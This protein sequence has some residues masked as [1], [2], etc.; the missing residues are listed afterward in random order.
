MIGRTTLTLR[1]ACLISGLTITLFGPPQTGFSQ[2]NTGTENTASENT[3]Q[4]ASEQVSET[5]APADNQDTAA[6]NF[7]SDDSQ[8]DRPPTASTVDGEEVS[9]GDERQSQ[10]IAEGELSSADSGD[11]S[12][13]VVLP[14]DRFDG[15]LLRPIGVYQSQLVGLV[16]KDFIPVALDE[17]RT[18]LTKANEQSSRNTE[19]RLLNAFYDVRLDDQMLVSDHSVLAFEHAVDEGVRH[20]LGRV[21]LAIAPRR[22]VV[23]VGANVTAGSQSRFEAD[24]DGQ[25]IAVVPKPE[26]KASDGDA[27]SGDEAAQ[28]AD[29]ERD[30]SNAEAKVDVDEPVAVRRSEIQFSWTL[31][32][33]SVGAMRKYDLRLP[34]AAQTRLVISV[35]QDVMLESRHG[36]LVERPGPPPDAD[37]QSRA[38]DIRWYVLEAGGLNRVE[39]YARKRATESNSNALIVR[40]ETK[41][42]DVDL[43]GLKWTHHLSLEMPVRR[44]QM[45]LRCPV[46][47][48][49]DVQ[50]NFL[51][52]NYQVIHRTDGQAVISVQIPGKFPADETPPAP[53]G[54]VIPTP[55]ESA[56]ELMTLTV[57]GH[58]D[59]DLG[60][61]LCYLPSV[62]PMDQ[63]VYWSPT[64][65]T[66]RITING[67][68]EVAKW[69]LPPGWQQSV[70]QVPDQQQTILTGE[71]PSTS[72]P[73]LTQENS[74]AEAWSTIGLIQRDDRVVNHIWT[75]MRV[76]EEPVHSIRATTR[77]S[78]RQSAFDLSPIMIDA[79]QDWIIDEVR[80]VQTKRRVNVAPKARVISIWPSTTESKLDEFEIEIVSRRNLLGNREILRVPPSWIIRPRD[81]FVHHLIAVQA[82]GRRRWNGDSV[83]LPD[84]VDL[85]SLDAQAVSFLQPMSE[86]IL[87]QS[88]SG[89]IPALE[90]EQVDVSIGVSLKHIIRDQ[91]GGIAETIV[92]RSATSQPIRELGVLTGVL[93]EEPFDWSLRRTDHSATVSLPPSDISEPGDDPLGTY[94][95]RL[96]GREFS[97]YELVGR[98]VLKSTNDRISIQLPSVRDDSSQ[99]AELFLSEP[100]EIDA[101][102]EGVALVPGDETLPQ[103]TPDE[104]SSHLSQRLRYDPAMRPEINLQKVPTESRTCL[105]WKQNVEVIASS[106]NEDIVQ[107][108]AEIST[109][110]L[111][112]IS[113]D[114][115][116]ELISIQ[117]NGIR[118]KISQSVDGIWFTPEN[119]TD[120]IS[121]SMRRRHQSSGWLRPC[122]APQV[123]VEGHRLEQQL[124]YTTD[125][126]TVLLY[127]NRS[128]RTNRGN[129]ASSTTKTTPQLTTDMSVTLWLM[130]RHIALAL[131]WLASLVMVQISWM[132]A[133]YVPKGINVLFI[134]LVLTASSAVIFWQW[135]LPILIWLAVPIALGGLIH[136][137]N[138]RRFVPPGN[139][140]PTLS[141]VL[142]RDKRESKDSVDFSMT[143]SWWIFFGGLAFGLAA[144]SARA[145]SNVMPPS[146]AESKRPIELLLPLDL[147]HRPTGDKVYLSRSD[148]DQLRNRVNADVAVEAKFQSASYRIILEPSRENGRDLDAEIQADYQITTPRESAKLRLPIRSDVIRRIELINGDESQIARFSVDGKTGVIVD[149]PRSN[150]FE[151]RVTFVPSLVTSRN[152]VSEDLAT[153]TPPSTSADSIDEL[154]DTAGVT[155]QLRLAIPIVHMA[156]LI[157]EAPREV[158]VESLGTP[159]GRTLS[160][161]ELGRYEADLGPVGEI[162]I[163]YQRDRRVEVGRIQSLRRTYRI[164]A[165]VQSTIVECEIDSVTPIEA[166]Q[167]LS[168]TILGPP[169]T[170]LDPTA[171]KLS[172]RAR[173]EGPLEEASSASSVGVYQFIKQTETPGPI[174]LFWQLQSLLNDPTSTEDRKL[175][176]VPDVVATNSS[177][178]MQTMF[179]IESAPAVR[180]TETTSSS[181]AVNSDDFLNRWVGYSG[182]L[183]RAF[184]VENDFPSFA[185]WQD[186]D[187][188]ASLLMQHHLHVDSS[189]LTLTL[190]AIVIDPRPVTN[191]VLIAIPKGFELLR[192]SIN[193]EAS[194]SSLRTKLPDGRTGVSLGDRRV[195][196]QMEI[197]L[198]CQSTLA[199]N[200]K[201]VIPNFEAV[202]AIGPT[203]NYRVTR[204]NTVSVELTEQAE[205]N[206]IAKPAVGRQELLA[207]QIPVM[208]IPTSVMPPKSDKDKPDQGRFGS[209]RVRRL[210]R[211]TAVDCN[212]TSLMRYVDGQWVCNT[213]L[214]LTSN[215]I[216][217]YV[218]VEIPGAW[219]K[220]V[221]V[222]NAD[223]WAMRSSNDLVVSVVRIHFDHEPSD[224]EIQPSSVLL[225][226]TL[227]N[228]DQGRVTVPEIRVLGNIVGRR[229]VLLPK[230][231]TTEKIDWRRRG[232]REAEL[233]HDW[234]ERF[235][236]IIDD[237]ALY[238]AY[239]IVTKNWSIRL[240]PLSQTAVDPVALSCDARVFLT[241]ERATVFQ[242]FDV[243]PE[244]GNEV[245]LELP[246]NAQCIGVWAAGREISQPR[247]SSHEY[248]DDR[249]SDESNNRRRRLS[250]P[251]AY[252]RLPQSIEIF[253]EIESPDKVLDDYLCKPVNIPSGIQWLSL[254]RAPSIE[255]DRLLTLDEAPPASSPAGYDEMALSLAQSVVLAIERSRDLLAERSDAEIS[256]WLLPWVGRYDAIASLAGHQFEP[257][258][259]AS[260]ERIDEAPVDE[261]PG[262]ESNTSDEPITQAQK[263]LVDPRWEVMDERLLSFAGRFITAETELPKPLLSPLRFYDYELLQTKQLD[264]LNDVPL[265][266]QRFAK[267]EG[268]QRTLFNIITMVTFALAII[269]LWPFRGRYRHWIT[270]P[271]LWLLCIGLL[272]L[273]FIPTP[274]ALAVII[275]AITVPAI[276]AHQSRPRRSSTVSGRDQSRAT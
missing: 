11:D 190:N 222:E 153:P 108:S 1:F 64:T 9:G 120:R 128:Q 119:A 89:Q 36:V 196:G 33:E 41:Q 188:D 144:N 85:K 206:P 51:E 103:T 115:D 227:D 134:G 145:Q 112:H 275:T 135:Q 87:L 234:P 239:T 127:T 6:D 175:L 74:N 136:V 86:T 88:D 217:D 124:I 22:T 204:T 226:C 4:E 154:T 93:H 254:F 70:Q 10:P 32:G 78:F 187:A 57:T 152:G 109:R 125:P 205:S 258:P 238:S 53:E 171:W 65:T 243:L 116:L 191:R 40:R 122:I 272:S 15:R 183:A 235:D 255:S 110:K 133:K 213:L 98:R 80:V 123:N 265:L 106:R 231:L 104:S 54:S 185:L 83:L 117:Q 163:K 84:R 97:D 253:L 244:Q 158:L 52:A 156:N 257:R 209:L 3:A 150:R 162:A 29:L 94:V 60:N 114:E 215:R 107:M 137:L 177:Q 216:P 77:L 28:A 147:D 12:I 34:R 247:Q 101:V 251:L 58:A 27:A 56:S 167:S 96:E 207:G 38:G 223:V 75:R 274:V 5:A 178:P 17:L 165:G 195:D 132:I 242:R 79:N 174:R 182:P 157:V 225:S 139:D 184:M 68:I 111:I 126:T 37:V 262:S 170:N 266:K 261:L 236:G 246:P 269:L 179:G 113:H 186:K 143:L 102:P 2:E 45:R 47:K 46:G 69:D 72:K 48:V 173:A 249:S 230:R 13:G 219:A 273:F 20:E 268:L 180:L 146:E 197:E 8:N 149:T 24:A 189:T 71:G 194:A 250:V 181:I 25:L 264:S 192:Q 44:E 14:V 228:R 18:L 212:Q 140:D 43:S 42:Y 232:A 259:V 16:P 218:D 202:G 49:A 81:S 164:A 270:H 138:D 214:E 55:V 271:A 176:P 161:P 241:G 67:P 208:A 151:L 203:I 35:D 100:W 30:D 224:S 199:R 248:S 63:S 211:G 168:L 160:R 210:R 240:E 23:R 61:G 39:I 31:R 142:L 166:G 62:L 59:W 256:R 221:I 73:T 172:E 95:I 19:A 130:P 66:A 76:S 131:G 148:Y 193:G 229:T 105:V 90:L 200:G 169:P 121:L 276:K 260:G 245:V 263:D 118:P 220:S 7:A 252:S 26:Q 82:P 155:H 91:N 237:P 201:V 99:N 233:P 159:F 50:L 21:N 198:V 141:D 92:I 267:H 129:E